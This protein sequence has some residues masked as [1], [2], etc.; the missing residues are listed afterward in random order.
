[1]TRLLRVIAAA[2]LVTVLAGCGD[3]GLGRE[4]QLF[5]LDV[6]R[7]DRRQLTDGPQSYSSPSWSRDSRQLAVAAS[8]PESGAIEVVDAEGTERRTVVR[9]GGFIQGVAWSPRAS[10]LAYVRLQEPAAWTLETVEAD[11]SDRRALAGHRSDRGA[12]A[13][14]SWAPDGTQVAY[15]GGADTFVA[16]T[17]GGPSRLLLGDAWAPSWSPDGQLVLLT[18]RDALIAAPIDGK[19]P[20]TIVADLIDAHAAW[21]PTSNRIA[22]SGVTLAGDRRYYLYL[23]S[24]GSK[25]RLRV[26]SEVVADA[27]A[28][29]PDGRSL[30]FA[31]WDGSVRVVTLETGASRTLTQLR[32]AEIRDLAWSPDGNHLAFVARHVPED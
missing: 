2:W 25:R 26:A 31:T 14:P 19:R 20:L 27:P 24:V 29:S 22:F 6:E 12:L 15:T 7:G 17:R 13:G 8:G 10:T 28:W 4:A 11:G 32:N 1:V 16:A 18:R 23:V 3:Y 9:R 5:A 30:A 21:S